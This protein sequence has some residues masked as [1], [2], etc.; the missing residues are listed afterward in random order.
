[1]DCSE[2][3]GVCTDSLEGDKTAPWERFAQRVITIGGFFKGKG[4]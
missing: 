1:M 2:H 3:K 4:T